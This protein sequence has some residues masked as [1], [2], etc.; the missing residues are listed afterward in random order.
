MKFLC[1][2]LSFL[3]VIFSAVILAGAI[4]TAAASFDGE[5]FIERISAA[6]DTTQACALHL[7]ATEGGSL[8]HQSGVYE[9]GQ[10]IELVATPAAGYA[11]AGWYGADHTLISTSTTLVFDV[12]HNLAIT[13]EFKPAPSTPG[14][15]TVEGQP[16]GGTSDNT[17]TPGNGGSTAGSEND[18]HFRGIYQNYNSSNASITEQVFQSSLDS[19]FETENEDVKEIVTALIGTYT[20]SLFNQI[21]SL[22][23]K[24]DENGT[25]EELFMATEPAAFD[26]LYAQMSGILQDDENYRPEEEEIVHMLECVTKSESCMATIEAVVEVAKENT[27]LMESVNSMPEEV[28]QTLSN[29]L[30]AYYEAAEN[31]A[32]G[33]TVCQQ[34]ADLLG[35]TLPGSGTSEE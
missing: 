25:Q 3:T 31:G 1:S 10:H 8:N 9:N 35:I 7:T 30:S 27:V 34:I 19:L 26:A 12:H 11:F 14:S 29:A 6:T 21:G 24:E 28:Q 2:F 16:S 20:E 5:G 23:E 33:K 13:A 4:G 22:K 18:H 17:G 15:G 32:D